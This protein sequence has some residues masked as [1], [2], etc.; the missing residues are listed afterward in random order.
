MSKKSCEQKRRGRYFAQNQFFLRI[1]F[2]CWNT[3]MA[4]TTTNCVECLHETQGKTGITAIMRITTS[5]QL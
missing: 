2:K 3:E 1:V 5:L 4:I